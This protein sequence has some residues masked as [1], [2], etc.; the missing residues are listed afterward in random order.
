MV[1]LGFYQKNGSE[2]IYEAHFFA[3]FAGICAVKK[4]RWIFVGG[5]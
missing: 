4:H 2:A 5:S 3:L 1:K